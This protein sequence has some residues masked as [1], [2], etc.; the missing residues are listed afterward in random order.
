MTLSQKYDGTNVGKDEY[1][2]MYGRNKMISKNDT[3]YMKTDLKC[4]EAIDAAKM[5]MAFV[6]QVGVKAFQVKKFVVYGELMCNSGLFDYDVS[7]VSGS[8]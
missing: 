2:Q 6:I 5:K 3:T 1:G 7:G 8:F 4:V